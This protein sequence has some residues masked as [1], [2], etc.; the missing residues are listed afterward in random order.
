MGNQDSHLALPDSLAN[1]FFVFYMSLPAIEN[2]RW[3]ILWIDIGGDTSTIWHSLPAIPYSWENFFVPEG[4]KPPPSEPFKHLQL[5]FNQ[6]S[7]SIAINMF[8]FL[9]I[10]F[11]HGL[12]PS[13][14]ARL[15]PYSSNK[16]VRKHVSHLGHTF[17]IPGGQG[18]TIWAWANHMNPNINYTKFLEFYW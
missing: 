8:L 9:Y 15:M 2:L 11:L 16:T 12:K 10:Y 7:L 17:I 3:L 5:D 6:W 14:A 1:H 4:L 18:I 13:P